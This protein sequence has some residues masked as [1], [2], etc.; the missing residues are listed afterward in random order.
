MGLLN[1]QS[2]YT[3][4]ST[5]RFSFLTKLLPIH[6]IGDFRFL[7]FLHVIVDTRATLNGT[8]QASYQASYNE[9]MTFS[10]GDYRTRLEKA[11]DWLRKKWPTYLYNGDRYI[12]SVK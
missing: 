11:E 6:L 12:E 4:R 3:I 10:N 1:V 5:L 9:P 8:A 7:G 2:Y